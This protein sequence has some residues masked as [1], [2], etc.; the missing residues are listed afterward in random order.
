MLHQRRYT[1]GNSMNE[2]TVQ[3]HLQMTKYN[4]K[5]RCDRSLVHFNP[6]Q[7]KAFHS[8]CQTPRASFMKFVAVLAGLRAALAP[9]V[10]VPSAE[11]AALHPQCTSIC[12]RKESQCFFD[13]LFSSLSIQVN[14][15][16]V[17]L[18]CSWLFS[19]YFWI[20]IFTLGYYLDI[21]FQILII[22]RGKWWKVSGIWDR[23][24]RRLQI[25]E[26]HC[27]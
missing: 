2:K 19:W 7:S 3:C 13:S 10:S 26:K 17:D 18:P 12:Q 14:K 20:I 24:T 9:A 21:W 4:L 16:S 25:R 11:Q 22:P 15:P 23:K 27:H 5:T 8:L 6:S 1:D